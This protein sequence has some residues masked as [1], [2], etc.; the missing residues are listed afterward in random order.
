MALHDS[1]VT[2]LSKCGALLSQRVQGFRVLLV[3]WESGRGVH[4]GGYRTD[5]LAIVSCNCHGRF[6]KDVMG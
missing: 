6:R 1:V 2:E 4:G 5:E 3:K